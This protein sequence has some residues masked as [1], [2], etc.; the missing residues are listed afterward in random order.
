MPKLKKT[1]KKILFDCDPS[2]EY[3]LAEYEY[4]CH[5][6][7]H[8]DNLLISAMKFAFSFYTA[9]MAIV[10][11]LYEHFMEGIVLQLAM[12]LSAG[13]IIGFIFLFFTIR[14]RA[15]YV[16]AVKQVVSLRKF[17]MDN[18]KIDFRPY[19]NLYINPNKVV[20]F[21]LFSLYTFAIIALT[22]FNTILGIAAFIMFCK[23]LYQYRASDI[24]LFAII[25][26]AILIFTFQIY[27]AIAYLRSKEEIKT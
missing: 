20:Y 21:K 5:D 19:N 4:A 13:F 11:A 2:I 25:F 1:K 18:L 16:R 14:N 3:L 15:H 22:I 7:Q 27:L 9:F 10:I 24:N 12:L 8:H 17:F 26:L 23:F 6:A